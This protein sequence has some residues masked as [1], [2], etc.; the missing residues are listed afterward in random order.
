VSGIEWLL[1][2]LLPLLEPM[3]APAQAE[4]LGHRC[5]FPEILPRWTGGKPELRSGFMRQVLLVL[6]AGLVALS[7][8]FGEQEDKI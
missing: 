4:R 2:F 3:T 1:I 6:R 8:N 5:E 7:R